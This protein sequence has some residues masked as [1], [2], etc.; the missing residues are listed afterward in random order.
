MFEDVEFMIILPI[1]M[2]K[3]IRLE[4]RV[5]SCLSNNHLSY[6]IVV[7]AS[8][9]WVSGFMFGNEHNFSFC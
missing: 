7:L 1:I 3:P 6:V 2:P 8:F 4:N 5:I 9:F